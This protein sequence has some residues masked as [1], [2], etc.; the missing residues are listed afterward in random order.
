MKKNS[1]ITNDSDDQNLEILN[2]DAIENQMIVID[3]SS[4]TGE[5]NNCFNDPVSFDSNDCS[6]PLI[7]IITEPGGSI[8]S[9]Y[10]KNLPVD[11]PTSHQ[12]DEI[13]KINRNR[14]P[15]KSF[16]LPIFSNPKLIVSERK[17]IEEVKMRCLIDE[18]MHVAKEIQNGNHSIRTDL[19]SF[20][21]D[22][23]VILQQINN[24]LDNIVVPSITSSFLDRILKGKLST[25][26][27]VSFNSECNEIV[28][29][30]NPCIDT[31]SYHVKDTS[32]SKK[33]INKQIKMTLNSGNNKILIENEKNFGWNVLCGLPETEDQQNQIEEESVR[34]WVGPVPLPEYQRKLTKEDIGWSRLCELPDSTSQ[35]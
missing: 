1:H 28:T 4:F 15:L 10:P 24:I 21:G 27:P 2:E 11:I 32:R 31:L 17:S 6:A 23:L 7:H 20:E 5:I 33:E 14:A 18:I 12:N 29:K 16:G 25:K 26:I 3:H 8:M 13:G 22:D 35:I 30:L 9:R 34:S 19:T